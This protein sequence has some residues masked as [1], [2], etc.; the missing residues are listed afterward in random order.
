MTPDEAKQTVLDALADLPSGPPG[1]EILA[2]LLAEAWDEGYD[3]RASEYPF[4]D[5]YYNPY[6]KEGAE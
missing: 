5:V 4:G 3:S 6:R 2:V 1:E